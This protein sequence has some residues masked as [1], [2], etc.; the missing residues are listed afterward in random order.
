MGLFDWL[1]RKDPQEAN[2]NDNVSITRG[3]VEAID[4]NG[5]FSM[6]SLGGYVCPSGGYLNWAT[7]EV[8]GINPETKRKEKRS[9]SAQ[10]EA[11]A[12]ELAEKYGL[13]DPVINAALPHGKPSEWQIERTAGWKMPADVCKWDV[14][15]ILD[16][17]GTEGAEDFEESPTEEFAMFAHKMGVSFSRF[18]GAKALHEH[19][20]NRLQFPDKAAFFAYCVLC[21]HKGA[22]VGDM[23]KAPNLEQLYAFGDMVRDNPALIRSIN[24]RD[25]A[26]YLKPNKGTAAYKAVAEYFNL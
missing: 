22:A 14:Y 18:I 21:S 16:R 11:E 1:K 5:P 7:Y 24:G 26:D 25:P 2:V 3:E 17:Q 8:A 6:V 4:Y 23:L 13:Q 10:D 19:V 9:Y 15:A 12:L 20:V